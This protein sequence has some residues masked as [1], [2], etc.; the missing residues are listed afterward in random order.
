MIQVEHLTKR[1]GSHTVLDDFSLTFEQ[2]KIYGVVGRNGSGKTVL[3]KCICG[4]LKPTAGTVTADRQRIGRDVDMLPNAGIIL[5]SPG[6]LPGYSGLQNLW[7]LAG[8][9]RKIRRD[10]C[11]RAMVRVGLDPKDRKRVSRYSMGMRQRLGIAQA[12]MEN[13]DILI[14]DEP[15]N[16]LDDGGVRE[17]HELLLEL[18]AQ[19]KLILL[20]SH[21]REDIETLCDIV[22]RMDHGKTIQSS[23]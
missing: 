23:D 7:F 19:G 18:K 22:I 8:L 11:A 3:F 16:G 17:I 6:F 1:F 2:G 21:S 9:R 14:L 5:E 4:F 20:A 10:D 15:T 13:P 12:I